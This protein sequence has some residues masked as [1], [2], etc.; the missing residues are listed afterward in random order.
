MKGVLFYE[1]LQPGGMVSAERYGRK[2]IDLLDASAQKRPFSGQGSRE[3][4]G[5]YVPGLIVWLITYEWKGGPLLCKLM[6]YVDAFA[7]A[8]SSNIMVCIALYRLYALRY[9]LWISAVGHNRVPRMLLAAW[10]IA[11]V[12]TLPQWFVWNEVDFGEITQCVTIWTEKINMP[13][14]IST[15]NNDSSQTIIRNMTD[16]DYWWMKFYG[17]QNV[18]ITFYIPLVI[19]IFCYLLIL[20][21]IYATL[22][23]DPES[24]SAMYLSEISKLSTCSKLRGSKKEKESFGRV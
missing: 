1:L 23:S 14:V 4:L 24:S 3:V 2:L 15:S 7:F 8:I 20:K 22:N 6:R 17:I 18:V 13:Q 12:T 10:G 19:L 5:L 9:P 16:D 11:A 21:D